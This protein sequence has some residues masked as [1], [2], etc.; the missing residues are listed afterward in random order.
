MADKRYAPKLP[1]TIEGDD[2]VYISDTLQNLKQQLKM[3]ILTN[4]GEKIMDP[5]FGVGIRKYLFEPTSG[6]VQTSI[7]DL[8]TLKI[9]TKDIKQDLI[10]NI[11]KQ[12]NKYISN[13]TIFDLNVNIDE[14][15]IFL[16]IY[17]NYKD[18]IEDSLVVSLY[19]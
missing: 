8:N 7:G 4:P 16:K 18:F 3:L 15:I 1:I 11:T 19:I 9:N 2:F 12:V 5:G 6:V 17:Y 13:V 10:L 14:N